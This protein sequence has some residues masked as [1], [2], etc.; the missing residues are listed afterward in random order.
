[1]SQMKTLVAILVIGVVGLGLAILQW[2]M[3]LRKRKRFQD[4]SDL[5]CED[6]QKLFTATGLDGQEMDDFLEIVAEAAEIPSAKLRPGDRFDGN[7]APEKGWELDDGLEL[8]PLAL[9]RRFGGSPEDYDLITNATL[10]DLLVA[11]DRVVSGH[12]MKPPRL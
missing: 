5:S 7:L 9:Q 1:M 10:V 6:L 4:R 8:L 2:R 11:V 12:R 3:L